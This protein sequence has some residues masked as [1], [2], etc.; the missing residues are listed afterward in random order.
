MATQPTPVWLNGGCRREESGRVRRRRAH[1]GPAASLYTGDRRT[2]S[3]GTAW[4]AKDRSIPKDEN[5]HHAYD[6]GNGASVPRTNPSNATT[7][8][9]IARSSTSNV[10]LWRGVVSPPDVPSLM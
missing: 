10:E 3:A 8:T 5:K 1:R 7:P 4:S 2:A 6:Y 9:Q